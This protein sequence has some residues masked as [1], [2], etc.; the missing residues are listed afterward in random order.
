MAE[1]EQIPHSAGGSGGGEQSSSRSGA[2]YNIR[3]YIEDPAGDVYRAEAL[4]TT[5]VRDVASDFFEERRW[6]TRGPN[7]QPMRGVVERIDPENADRT[8]RLNSNHT[9][10][11]A[12]VRDE[13]TLRVLPESVAG[14]VNPHERLRALVVDQREM[15]ELAASDPEHIQIK[16]NADHAPNYYEVTLR[17][18]GIKLG[19]RGPAPTNEHR[20]EIFLPAGYPL[21]APVV[22]WLTPIFHPNISMR[23]SVCLGILAERYLPGIGL[24]YIVRMLIDIVRYRNYDLQGVYNV[25]ARTW[26]QS[27]EGQELIL[28]IGGVPEEQPM[29]VLLEQLR[30]AG[31]QRTRFTRL[32]VDDE[33]F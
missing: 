23:G 4:S 16:T 12:G 24:A 19:D 28:G 13:D 1:P 15:L 5:L 33:D 6:P 27:P 2:A 7:G 30:T 22:N 26:A 29:D 17:Y 10:E 14:A 32:N 9:L 18:T 20:V 21:Q 31:R 3:F 11:E 8:E 25:D